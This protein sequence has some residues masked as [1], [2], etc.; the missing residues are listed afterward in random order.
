MKRLVLTVTGTIAGVAALLS[1]KTQ[2][3]PIASGVALPSA[4]LGTSSSAAATPAVGSSTSR[5]RRS[6]S[7]T[8]SR[9]RSAAAPRKSYLGSA[10]TTRYGVVRVKVNVKGHT[11]TNVAFAELTAFDGHSQQINSEAG[12]LLLR[13]TLSAQSANVDTISGASYTSDGYR[14]SLQSALD[15]AGIK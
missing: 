14:Q 3:H 10:V 2:S 4:S 1:F 9:S 11:I 6:P 8:P 12:P 15:A 13:E 7:A 5:A